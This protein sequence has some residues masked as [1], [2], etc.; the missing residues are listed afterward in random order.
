MTDDKN[1][2]S[3]Y[4]QVEEVI[5]ELNELQEKIDDE[6]PVDNTEVLSILNSVVS[7]LSH[8]KSMTTTDNT[9]DETGT[10]SQKL[11]YALNVLKGE[12]GVISKLNEILTHWTSTRAGYID[13]LADST[14]GL[15]KIK[16]VVDTI[17]NNVNTNMSDNTTALNELKETANLSNSD[18]QIIKTTINELLNIVNS[19]VPVDNTEVLEKLNEI[20]QAV[21]SINIDSLDEN[22]LIVKNAIAELQEKIDSEAPVDNTEVLT[23][24]NTIKST[25]ETLNS[26][27]NDI[28]TEVAAVKTNTDTIGT[29][30]DTGGSATEGTV[31]GK[32]NK[33]ISD[34][35]THIAS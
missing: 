32:L 10:I 23:E 12:L 16:S 14:Y 13:K 31:F 11:T 2:I 20:N 9:S 33:I 18:I 26:A 28:D 5:N 30:S 19:E 24:L 35:A 21:S 27:I 17:D 1:F 15:D 34:L 8:I 4:E 29:T 22:I 25:L 7:D 3:T 6:A